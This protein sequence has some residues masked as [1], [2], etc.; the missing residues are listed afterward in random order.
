MARHA[1]PA[2]AGYPQYSGNLIHPIVGQELIERFY[3]TSVF[4]DIASTEYIGELTKGGDQIT[5]FR[6]PTVT[7]RDA[8]KA[9][10]IIHDTLE[11]EPVTVVIDRAK[12]FSLNIAK[13]DIKQ[14]KL[15]EVFKAALLK[16]ASRTMANAIDGEIL[17]S[18]YA[19]VAASNQGL[20]AGVISSSYNLG[21]TGTPVAIDP[22]NVLSVLTN[23]H[24]VLNEAQIP[25]EDRWVVIPTQLEVAILNSDLKAAYFSGMNESTYLNGRI[26]N[27]VANFSVYV[28]DHVSRVF[29]SGSGTYAYHILAGTRQGICFA[30]QLE[31][32]RVIE[33]KDNWNE[34]YQGLQ[35][36]GFDVIQPTA[37]AHL[38][39]SVTAS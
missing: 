19:S 26:P 35:V 37:L 18:V 31:E 34:Y 25:K 3:A 24:G 39:A 21:V 4:G 16:N 17:G 6:E 10:T 7:I 8:Q 38:F 33:D 1:I 36:Y 20:T 29:D 32:T 15:W 14:M 12:E 23:L 28:S 2:A 27:K 13:I 9:G 22:S 11:S 5:F 30:S